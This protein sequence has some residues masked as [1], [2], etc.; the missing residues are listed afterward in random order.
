MMRSYNYLRSVIVD[1]YSLHEHVVRIQFLSLAAASGRLAPQLNDFATP[2]PGGVEAYMCGSLQHASCQIREF[3]CLI[4]LKVCNKDSISYV[5]FGN[6]LSRQ[7][8]GPELDVILFPNR[9]QYAER[10][11][12]L[13]RQVKPLLQ[14]KCLLKFLRYLGDT[15]DNLEI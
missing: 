8:A 11:S 3:R 2:P 7:S 9:S 14:L 6:T 1:L 5:V 15:S 12:S 4:G 13:H 10:F